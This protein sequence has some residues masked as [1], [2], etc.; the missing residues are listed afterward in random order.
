MTAMWN[1]RRILKAAGA[2]AVASNFPR[3]SLGKTLSGSGTVVV[4]DGGGA[5]G[6]AKRKAYFEPF[7]KETGI[8][9]VP[10]PRSAAGVL[11]AS[12][13]A[14]APKYDVFSMTGG[15]MYS[16][17]AE[18]LLLPIDYGWWE[19]ADR[20]AIE[21]VPALPY[22]VPSVYYSLMMAYANEA[23][24]NKAPRSWA[25]F[26]DVNNFPGQR[27]LA[28]GATGSQGGTF[29]AA[30][31][32]DG[33]AVERLYPLDWDRA[34][35]SLS[36]I[37]PSI[38]K[39]WASGA[40]PVQLLMDKQVSAASAWNGRVSSAK[41]QG[42]KI[43]GVWN[44]GVLQWDSWVVPKGASNV[45]NAMKFIAF[46]SRPESQARFVEAILY[47][48]TNVKAFDHLKRERIELL[49]TAPPL[50]AQQVVQDYS[51]WG[52]VGANGETNEKRAIVEWEKWITGGR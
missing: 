30:L 25:D 51:W 39:W 52:A 24:T 35:K 36:R 22:G 18:K 45:E 7:E 48:P 4:Y 6:D 11:R 17:A 41:D 2:G 33:V 12:V 28:P 50:R 42:A 10:Q 32:A 34:F 40:E 19:A 16:F 38:V 21:P 43:T 15:T 13:L 20:A 49:P 26:W 27:A 29:E 9:V 47:G 1:R 44:Q 3:S 5:W 31:L 46:V 14:G 23:F 37:R 8:K